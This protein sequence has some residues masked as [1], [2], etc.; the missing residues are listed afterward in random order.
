MVFDVASKEPAVDYLQRGTLPRLKETE[1]VPA[2][3]LKT[4]FAAYDIRCSGI[5]SRTFR[6]ISP[7][8]DDIYEDILRRARS[9]ANP[10]TPMERPSDFEV[11]RGDMR[12]AMN[13]GVSALSQHHRRY[14]WYAGLGC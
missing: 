6:V 12:R 1:P 14:V 2:P 8:Q 9:H 7:D 3:G 10:Y 11:E 4:S 13:P 5:T